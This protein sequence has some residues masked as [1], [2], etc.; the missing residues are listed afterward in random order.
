MLLGVEVPLALG[1]HERGDEFLRGEKS[2]HPMNLTAIGI[3]YDY[4][5]SPTDIELMHQRLVRDFD[6]HW[7]KI[8]FHKLD[9]L[10]IGVRN[11]THLLTADSLGVEKVQE[12]G[13]FRL[14]GSLLSFVKIIQPTDLLCHDKSSFVGLGLR[15]LLAPPKDNHF[16][17]QVKRPGCVHDR[18]EARLMRRI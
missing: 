8:N 15:P 1:H 13:L 10:L 12:N 18:L 2:H 16:E 4:G 3:Q 11:R 9:D 5:G 14:P 6:L 17:L 7:R